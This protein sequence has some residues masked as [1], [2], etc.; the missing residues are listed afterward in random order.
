M[1]D[2]F[3]TGMNRT[4]IATSPIEGP[5]TIQGAEE[6]DG[7]VVDGAGAAR[8]RVEAARESEPIGTV[9]PPAS[10]RGAAKTV[11]KAL[12]GEK[13]SVFIDKLGERAAFERTGAR[14]YELALVKAEAYPTW[15]GG[16]TRE[17]LLE[18]QRDE[19]SHFGL[20]MS[21]LVKLGADPTAMTPS[22]DIAANLS[23]GVPQV[24]ADPRTNLRQ[25][26]EGLL[27]AELT[28][29]ACWETLI[30][31][32]QAAGQ[33][34]MVPAFEAARQ[35]EALHLRRVKDWLRLGISEALGAKPSADQPAAR[36]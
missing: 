19:L 28:D 23:K 16:P 31:L 10:I 15:P 14:L 24:L 29:N 30:E 1:K 3:D 5:K 12:Q 2:A 25:C 11:L 36:H 20:V 32:A 8:A 13:A 4:G 18:I 26:L 34:D 6:G 7:A 33:D 22:A 21:C 9:P 35:R 17:D 27:V